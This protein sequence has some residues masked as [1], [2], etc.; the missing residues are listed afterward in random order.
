MRRL[1]DWAEEAQAEFHHRYR[2]Y[3][4]SCHLNPPC[5]YCTDEGNPENLAENDDAWEEVD[6]SNNASG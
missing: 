5:G 4:C 6:D 2:D 1:K 3:G